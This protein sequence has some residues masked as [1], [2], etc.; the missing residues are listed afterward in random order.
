MDDRLKKRIYAFYFAGALNLV[1][2]LYVLGFGDKLE[3]GTRA[4]ML[5][6]FFGFAALDFWFP[7]Q[8]KKKLAEQVALQQR[9][10]S[11]Q[12]TAEEKPS[13]EKER[14]LTCVEGEYTVIDHGKTER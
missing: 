14:I 2:A 11:E 12:A 7:Q 13:S 1:L 6:F 4:I 8:L 3:P 5:L 10:Q 9:L